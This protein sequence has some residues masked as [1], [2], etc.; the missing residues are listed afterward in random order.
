LACFSV[1]LGDLR[2][3]ITVRLAQNHQVLNF[4]FSFASLFDIR[5][6]ILDI[7]AQNTAQRE[8]GEPVVQQAV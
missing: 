1:Y 5:E 2:F 6:G 7:N 8:D 3:E 4:A